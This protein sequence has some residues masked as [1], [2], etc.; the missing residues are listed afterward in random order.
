MQLRRNTLFS[1]GQLI[2]LR[3]PNIVTFILLARWLGTE[4]A[5]EFSLA[6]TYA[7]VLNAWWVG[8]DEWLIRTVASLG[9]RE[10]KHINRIV[11][12]YVR[13]RVLV[14]AILY[15][16][17]LGLLFALQQQ[18]IYQTNTSLTL[19]IFVFSVLPDAVVTVV[20][21]KLTGEERFA[22]IFLITAVQSVTKL[23][24]LAIVLWVSPSALAVAVGWSL[25]SL[26]HCAWVLWRLGADWLLPAKN[27]T[28]FSSQPPMIPGWSYIVI[29]VAATLEYQVDVILLSFLQPIGQVS[30]Y[31]VA[32][33]IFAAATLPLQALRSTLFPVMAKAVARDNSIPAS[34]L[35]IQPAVE[36]TSMLSQADTLFAIS[37]S[38]ERN[39]HPP[40]S[41]RSIYRSAMGWVLVIAL[42]IAL[43]GIALAPLLIPWI[44][45]EDLH[46]AIQPTQFVLVALL[47]FALNIPQSRFLL[48]TGQQ[49]RVSYL[50]STT[51]LLNTLLNLWLLPRYGALGAALARCLSTATF[52]IISLWSV[53][54][55][56][57][58]QRGNE[59]V[60]NTSH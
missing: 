40:G 54:Q 43:L 5:G 6:V 14:T 37:P 52:L 20:Q 18:A 7:L 36:G 32:T 48:A 11:H 42:P 49:Q 19:A 31:S 45:G 44:F 21:A 22:H 53:W 35:E 27:N 4:T 34:V 55:S 51:V 9:E 10:H 29:G 16:G 17:L 58:W 38:A 13:R 26:L 2:A 23:L 59:A 50:I 12:S 41:M 3:I 30:Y 25:A 39:H 33:T 15:L 46:P 1:L 57:A 47:F 60:H 24:T 56:D 28:S 8:L